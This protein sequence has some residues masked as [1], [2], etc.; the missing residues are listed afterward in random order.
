[1][2]DA[3]DGYHAVPLDEESKPFT[4]FI[5]EWGR[6]RY[7]RLPQGFLASGDA[8]TRRYDEII[9]DVKDKVKCIDDVLLHDLDIATSFYHTFDYLVICAVN[10]VTL[11]LDKFQFAQL[12]L[13]ALGGGHNVPSP[14][15]LPLKHRKTKKNF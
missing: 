6:F 9:K 15:K 2:L 5:T 3:T 13:F 10:G 4:T 8:Y 14:Q 1:M 12:T 11:N 7:R